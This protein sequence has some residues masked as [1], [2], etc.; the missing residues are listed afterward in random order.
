MAEV[1]VTELYT[2]AHGWV[3]IKLYSE[4]TFDFEPVMLPATTGND[5]YPYLTDDA[6]TPIE[7]LTETH[8]W[9]GINTLGILPID[10]FEHNNVD[11][12]YRIADT[13][14]TVDIRASAARSG[15]YGWYGTG[16]A[17]T[18]S[19]PPGH[20]N[21]NSSWQQGF[22]PN[23]PSSGDIF[24]CYVKIIDRDRAGGNG[25]NRI[26]WHVQDYE[27]SNP[28]GGYRIFMPLN[29]DYWRIESLGSSSN[30]LDEDSNLP[31]TVYPENEWLRFVIDLR[32]T[33]F[34]V[35]GYR[36]SGSLFGTLSTNSTTWTSGGVG[37][38]NGNYA[39]SY[40]DDWR[41]IP[42]LP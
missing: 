42:E 9:L 14:G 2:Q 22:L 5:G 11:R 15:N 21:Y 4:G 3:E 41:I 20:P 24:E 1:G 32:G 19:L 28:T 31:W 30:T 16:D 8:G 39:I 7:V 38:D 27:E 29:G 26:H 23:Y 10:D 18:M 6:D 17:R 25:I 34:T 37:Y 40:T 13:R 35:Y 33:G 36:Q 12:Y